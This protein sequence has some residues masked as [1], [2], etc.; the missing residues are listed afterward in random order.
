MHSPEFAFEKDAGNVADAIDSYGIYYP[1][2]QDNDLGTW[3][4]FAN[5]YWPAKYLI[6][7]E[8]HVRYVHFGEGP[9]S[10]PNGRSARC[11][12]RPATRGSA[13]GRARGEDEPIDRD[14]GTPETYLGFAR[15][16]GFVDGPHPGGDY[17]AADPRRSIS[18]SSPSAASGRSARSRRRR[19]GATISLRFQARRVFLV[20]GSPGAPAGLQVL[21]DGEPIADADAGEDVTDATATIDK[22]RLYRLVDLPETGRHTLELRFAAAS[23]ATRSRSARRFGGLLARRRLRSMITGFGR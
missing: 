3:S 11:S 12:P 5:Q 22:Q 13:R 21:L 20:L 23:R 1:V 6:D 4:A 17:R 18:T 10:R 15:A 14:L 8:G 9:T 16:Q 19:A 7:A 2:V